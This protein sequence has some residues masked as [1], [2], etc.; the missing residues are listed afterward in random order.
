MRPTSMTAKEFLA[1][2]KALEKWKRKECE[3]AAL[4]RVRQPEEGRS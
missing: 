2:M 3:R 1:K 4:G